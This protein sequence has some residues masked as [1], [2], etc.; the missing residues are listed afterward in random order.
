M[1]NSRVLDAIYEDEQVLIAVSDKADYQLVAENVCKS[2]IA[3][4]L[5]YDVKYVG[6]GCDEECYID[7]G[8]IEDWYPSVSEL[9]RYAEM[10]SSENASK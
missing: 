8:L 4:Q 9:I 6:K 1:K 3:E 2:E 7:G 5:G 10:V